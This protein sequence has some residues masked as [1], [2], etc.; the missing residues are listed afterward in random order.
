MYCICCSKHHRKL[1]RLNK[2]RFIL[3]RWGYHFSLWRYTIQRHQFWRCLPATCGG[4]TCGGKTALSVGGHLL[5]QGCLLLNHHMH[6]ITL[7]YFQ[8]Q[9]VLFTKYDYV[10]RMVFASDCQSTRLLSPM[11]LKVCF[12]CVVWELRSP[13]HIIIAFDA[14]NTVLKKH[15][16]VAECIMHGWI[17]TFSKFWTLFTGAF[18]VHIQ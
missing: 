14:Y 2:F 4:K 11:L 10:R 15:I 3:S 12:V 7:G 16:F 1:A 9:V 8:V 6:K 17:I 18:A 13:F 5:G